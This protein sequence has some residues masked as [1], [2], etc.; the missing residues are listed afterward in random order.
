MTA[1]VF[2]YG[3][4][5]RGINVGGHRVK[6]DHLRT[7]FDAL[8]YADVQTLI[9]SGNVIFS[10]DSEDSSALQAEIETHLLAELGYEVATFIRTHEELAAVVSLTDDLPPTA[11]DSES[12]EDPVGACYVVF[13]ADPPD[14][15][16][17]ARFQA[18]SSA[19]DDFQVVGREVYWRLPGKISDSPLFG[20]EFDRMTKGVIS[21]TRNLTTVRK[22]LAKLA[23]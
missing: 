11:F 18:A 22:L 21:T 20:R 5:L 15:D 2:R 17:C 7:L 4:L 6:M 1:S 8:G 3:A 13:L 19:T 14:A 23:G 16:V 12:D 9:A 10:S